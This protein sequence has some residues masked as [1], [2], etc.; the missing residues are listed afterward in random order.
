MNRSFI[1]LLFFVQL[2]ACTDFLKR[3]ANAEDYYHKAL[4]ILEDNSHNALAK[5]LAREVLDLSKKA[6]VLDGRQSRYFRVHG[7]AYYHLGKFD[8]A[9]FDLEEAIR[10]DPRNWLAWMN[11]G[12]VL[13]HT[14]RF[15][16]AEKSYREALLFADDSSTVYYNLGMLYGKWGKVV[17]SLNAYNKVIRRNPD[18]ASA[19]TNR[20]HQKLKLGYYAEAIEDCDMAVSL[21]PN[22]K[23][24]FN[25]RGLCKYYLKDYKGAIADLQKAL[26]I[27]LGTPDEIDTDTYSLNNIANSWFALGNRE[28]A[29]VYWNK[30]V[31]AGYRYQP[32]WKKIYN[33]DDPKKL[34]K[35]YCR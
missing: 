26:S 11:K 5:S 28:Q 29:C 3:K 27:R 4:A 35:K 18:Y 34:I 15:P 22:D 19:Y 33:I 10:L 14:E 30:A 23:V 8:S 13:E 7:T 31:A 1:C 6:I 2:T 12:I 16:E 17:Q 20:G 24:S 25:N 21:D 32:E 9:M